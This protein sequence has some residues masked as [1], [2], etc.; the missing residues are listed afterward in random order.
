MQGSQDRQKVDAAMVF[1][2]PRDSRLID[3]RFHASPF[4][5]RERTAAL[6]VRIAFTLIVGALLYS[7]HLSSASAEALPRTFQSLASIRAAAEQ[8]VRDQG[9]TLAPANSSITVVAAELDAR[10]QLD[11]CADTLK[12]FALNGASITARTTVGIRCDRGAAWTVYVPVNAEAE[13]DV[14][15]LRNSMP[16]DA[17]VAKGDLETQ[18][19]HVAGIG[20]GY[21]NSET[22]LR[23]Q[24]LKHETLAGT[25]LSADL[26]TRDLVVKRGQQVLLVFDAHGL[27]VE[28]PGLALADGGT[29]DR[30]RVQNTTSLKI[31]EGVIESGN[32]VRVGM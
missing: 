8:F 17:H 22:T 27:A 28:A 25:P 21:I 32:L 15:V 29:A 23:E 18:R 16:R 9:Q 30:I 4:F 3:S 26:L 31:V 6:A 5:L 19:R 14:L 24:H 20:T 12:T 1:I 13:I 11:Q 7:I 10:L 2:R